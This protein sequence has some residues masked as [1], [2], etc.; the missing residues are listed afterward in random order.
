MNDA[1]KIA[2]GTVLVVAVVGLAEMHWAGLLIGLALALALWVM[3][4]AGSYADSARR[5][6]VR[7]NDF[8]LAAVVG[9][10]LGGAM[11]MFSD[12]AAMWS[13]GFILAGV[14]APFGRRAIE[15]MADTGNRR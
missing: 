12:N 10:V 15:D 7:G 4:F 1:T 14:M 9:L 13:V 5:G 3:L 11:A 2:L 8:L 6:A